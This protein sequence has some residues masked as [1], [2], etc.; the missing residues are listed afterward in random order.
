M[1][2]KFPIDC[3]SFILSIIF[4]QILPLLPLFIEYIY[5]HDIT[6]KSIT[7]S[8]SMYA[9]AISF[10]SKHQLSFGLFLFIGIILAVTF[11]SISV[12]KSIFPLYNS[13][14]FWIII[15]IFIIHSV[16]RIGRHLIDKEPYFLFEIKDEEKGK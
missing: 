15:G 16:E 4:H 3:Q 13:L 1:K 7:I 2:I 9:F 12:P 5:S 10:S 11:G 14:I 8:A 6:D